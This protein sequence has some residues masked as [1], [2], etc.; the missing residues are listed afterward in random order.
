MNTYHVF[1]IYQNIENGGS[2]WYQA[3]YEIEAV[4]EVEALREGI[5]KLGC[6]GKLYS[7]TVSRL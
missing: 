1:L 6:Y 7:S 4:N 3:V 5:E 2:T